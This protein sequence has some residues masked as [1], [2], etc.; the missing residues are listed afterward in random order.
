M[1]ERTPDNSL[2][3]M[4]GEMRGQLSAIKE[5]TSSLVTKLSLVAGRVT[6]LENAQLVSQTRIGLLATVWGAM[7]GSL[8]TVA[9]RKMGWL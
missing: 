7:G 5:D 6:V 9:L 1:N 3:L 2:Y 4:L 8:I